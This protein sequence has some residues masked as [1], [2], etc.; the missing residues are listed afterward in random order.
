MFQFHN[1]FSV[2]TESCFW[3]F[4]EHPSYSAPLGWGIIFC[5]YPAHS[6]HLP[7]TTLKTFCSLHRLLAL[8]TVTSVCHIWNPGGAEDPGAVSIPFCKHPF[9]GQRIIFA[10]QVGKGLAWLVPGFCGDIKTE[11]HGEF[12]NAQL[13]CADCGGNWPFLVLP[14]VLCSGEEVWLGLIAC[15]G[16]PAVSVPRNSSLGGGGREG[17]VFCL[18]PYSLS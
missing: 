2:C 6:R 12:P 10:S 8:I 17:V 5:S 7:S 9:C 13:Q 4:I 1:V 11:G 15:C 18:V 14:L 16:L 3:W